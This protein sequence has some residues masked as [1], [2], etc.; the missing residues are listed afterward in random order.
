MRVR[1]LFSGAHEFRLPAARVWSGLDLRA[2]ISLVAVLAVVTGFVS[3]SLMPYRDVLLEARDAL[4]SGDRDF[5]FTKDGLGVV[6]WA[7]P[8]VL[9]TTTLRTRNFP[10]GTP[11]ELGNR[12]TTEPKESYALSVLDVLLRQQGRDA[13]LEE[14]TD[15]VASACTTRTENAWQPH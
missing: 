11:P 13:F 12:G 1:R 15:S 14:C 5:V 3:G 10:N 8:D 2:F 4:C 7:Y 6:S 9:N